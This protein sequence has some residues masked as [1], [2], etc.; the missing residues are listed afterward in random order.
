MIDKFKRKESIMTTAYCM[1]CQQKREIKDP[2]Q[3]TLKNNSLAIQGTCPVCVAKIF[4]AG[5]L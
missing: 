2:K 3:V 5:K 4:R 1:K